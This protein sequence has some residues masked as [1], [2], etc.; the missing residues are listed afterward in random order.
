MRSARL[1]LFICLLDQVF[2]DILFQLPRCCCHRN[3]SF[4]RASE[5]RPI[6]RTIG[7]HSVVSRRLPAPA[8]GAGSFAR[9]V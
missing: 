2:G 8:T 9:D 7:Y 1:K 3:Q 5:L 6:A 4:E